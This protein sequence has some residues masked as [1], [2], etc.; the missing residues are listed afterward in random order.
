MTVESLTKVEKE[1]IV[2]YLS[3]QQGVEFESSLKQI[4]KNFARQGVTVDSLREFYFLEI[5]SLRQRQFG[6]RC[7]TA[8]T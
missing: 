8:F 2:N 3:R 4:A 1:D 7:T 6:S 5:R